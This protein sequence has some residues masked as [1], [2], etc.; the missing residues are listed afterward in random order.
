MKLLL[1]LCLYVFLSGP[2]SA[3]ISQKE[4]IYGHK[5]GMALTC[6][7]LTPEKS[8]YRGI[9]FVVSA[10]WQSLYGAIPTYVKLSDPFLKKGYTVF[11]VQH[12]SAPQYTVA[13]ALA[14]LRTA[15]RFIRF[16]AS[17]YNIHPDKIGIT[18]SS[19]G[20]HLALCIAMDHGSSSTQAHEPL[21]QVSAKVQAVACLYP[22]TDFI[23]FGKMDFNPFLD[24]KYLIQTNRAAAFDF[25][26]WSETEKKPVSILSRP[27]IEKILRDLS[28]ALHVSPSAPPT[29]II[30]GDADTSIPLQQSRQMI[31]RLKLAGV[32]SELVIKKGAG[33]GWDDEEPEMT[34]FADW[35]DKYLK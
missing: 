1:S 11:L 3:Q 22:L 13:D 29:L 6:Q 35:F 28:P 23:N 14:D 27:V 4:I 17:D 12:G 30:H 31:E 24:K 16:R 20:G 9:I 2:L 33:H 7:V 32:P 5:D 18:G 25:K 8:N 26:E 21:S 19:A 15:V 34:A 10:G